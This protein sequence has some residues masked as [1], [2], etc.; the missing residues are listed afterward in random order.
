MKKKQL[1]QAMKSLP[2]LTEDKEKFVNIILDNSGGGSQDD[3]RY[4][5]LNDLYHVIDNPQVEELFMS[6][7]DSAAYDSYG[8]K[9]IINYFLVDEEHS[10][11]LAVSI[12]FNRPMGSYIE[13]SGVLIFNHFFE[14]LTS[15]GMSEYIDIINNIPTITR[16]EF[17][18]LVKQ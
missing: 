5:M 16:E 1:L 9:G 6:Y 18:N 14:I 3:I 7:I 8:Y 13:E 11:I 10:D 2:M 12:N 4:Y 17:I 15:Q